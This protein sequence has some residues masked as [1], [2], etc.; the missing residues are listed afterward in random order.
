MVIVILVCVLC[1]AILPGMLDAGSVRIVLAVEH[2]AACPRKYTE[3][4]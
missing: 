3:K 4:K 2:A 1:V